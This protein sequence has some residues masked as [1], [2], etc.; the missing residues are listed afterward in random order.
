MS[1]AEP[2]VLWKLL[3]VSF[4]RSP[5]LG[6]SGVLLA[7]ASKDLDLA[8]LLG[9]SNRLHPSRVWVYNS[10]TLQSHRNGDSS[11]GHSDDHRSLDVYQ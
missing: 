11:D 1:L 3:E 4:R 10:R 8:L 7:V 9:C 5:G 2:L 6:F